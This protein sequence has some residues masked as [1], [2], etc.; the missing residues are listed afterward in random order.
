MKQKAD[1]F[2]KNIA[3]A[4]LQPVYFLQ[5]DETYY[6][7]KIANYLE[8]NV[9]AETERNF[10]QLVVYGKDA[11][12]RQVIEHAN[13]YPIGAKYMFIMV[14]EAQDL[15]DLNR[16]EGQTILLNYIKKPVKK[17]GFGFYI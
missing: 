1:S 7:D 11:N 3:K 6:I 15:N 12:L 2:F 5:G 17:F 10:N 16:K 9:L 4:P 8:Q 13:R 14:K